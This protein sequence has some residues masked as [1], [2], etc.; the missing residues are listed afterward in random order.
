MGSVILARVTRSK[1]ERRH[2]TINVSRELR[3]RLWRGLP[4]ASSAHRLLTFIETS[5]PSRPLRKPR[6]F[7]ALKLFIK[8]SL[9]L[10]FQAGLLWPCYSTSSKTEHGL[11]FLKGGF[12]IIGEFFFFL[13]LA[14]AVGATRLFVRRPA[15]CFHVLF[16]VFMSCFVFSCLVH[17]FTSCFLFFQVNYT[18]FCCF[19]SWF[20]S[21]DSLHAACRISSRS[22]PGWHESKFVNIRLLSFR[23]GYITIRTCLLPPV[24]GVICLRPPLQPQAPAN[25]VVVQLWVF[26]NGIYPLA[27]KWVISLSLR[28]G[29]YGCCLIRARSYFRRYWRRLPCRS[30]PWWANWAISVVRWGWSS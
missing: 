18:Q 19:S 9:N 11:W 30:R 29:I 28:G 21:C 20:H 12:G 1:P 25:L 4:Q 2:R 10:A 22:G 8:L 3:V 24:W 16:Y 13:R 14:T 5:D 27:T 17:I 7:Y 15:L 6:T 23:A 26:I